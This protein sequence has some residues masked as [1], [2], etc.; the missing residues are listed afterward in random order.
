MGW[1]LFIHIHLRT[2]RV[3]TTLCNPPTRY[4]SMKKRP[5]HALPCRCQMKGMSDARNSR[6]EK[7]KILSEQNMITINSQPRKIYSIHHKKQMAQHKDD[8]P[9]WTDSNQFKP[10]LKTHHTNTQK[11]AFETEKT[12]SPGAADFLMESDERNSLWKELPQN[13]VAHLMV[14]QWV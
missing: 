2:P 7:K 6:K 13:Q 11:K 3:R 8:Y 10:D 1:E 4:T 14:F 5:R 9:I 12:L